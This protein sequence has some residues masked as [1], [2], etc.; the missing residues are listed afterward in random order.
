MPSPNGAID[1]RSDTVTVPTT[2]MRHAMARAEVGDDGY[3]ED[4]TVHALEEL[5]AELTGKE[6]A[7]FCASGVLANQLALKVLA[8]A[9][10]AVV[11]GARSHIYAYELGAAAANSGVLLHPLPDEDGVLDPE[12]VLGVIE[13]VRHHQ[14]DVSLVSVENTYMPAHGRPSSAEQIAEVAWTAAAHGIPLYCD[15]ARLFNA[16]V[17]LE[18][19]AAELAGP[20]DAVMFCVSKGLGAPAGSLLCARAAVVDEAR[21]H[22]KRLGGAM[23]QVGILA[24]AG[25]VALETMVD[26]LAEDHARA[27]R[28]AEILADR[29]PGAVDPDRVHTNIVCARAAALPHDIVG[30]LAEHRIKA[31]TID[32]DTVRFVTHK[33]IDDSDLLRFVDV[34][35]AMADSDDADAG[36]D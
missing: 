34:L 31:G 15:G 24:A 20:A 1:L 36:A 3:G 32:A 25:I 8:Q 16:A 13:A 7:L 5:A 2:A 17:A 19:T 12:A 23:R 29:C 26:R 21:V 9:G 30:R 10:T 6:A 27:R 28:I 18:E 14:P 22:R 4:P 35:D 33:D 11:C